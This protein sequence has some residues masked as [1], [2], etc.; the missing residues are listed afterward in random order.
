VSWRVGEVVALHLD[1][2]MLEAVAPGDW[3][4]TDAGARYLVVA[5]RH[6]RGRIH[7]QRN[8]WQLQVRRLERGC[9]VPDDVHCWQMRWYPRARRTG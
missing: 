8:R 6:V 3:I 9:A 5:S 7:D 1:V 2:P 4:A